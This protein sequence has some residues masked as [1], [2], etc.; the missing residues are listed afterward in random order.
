MNDRSS[1]K[2][3]ET[4]KFFNKIS[5]SLNRRGK[6]GV[7]VENSKARENEQKKAWNGWNFLT[8]EQWMKI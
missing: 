2:L 3:Y 5:H 6:V 7:R 1:F 4:K 8:Q